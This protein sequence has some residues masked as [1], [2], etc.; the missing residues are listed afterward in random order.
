MS[1][2]S[3]EEQF[4]AV[5]AKKYEKLEWVNKSSY[6]D[7]FLASGQFEKSH[8]VLDVGTGTGIIAHS[9]APHVKDVVGVD[10]SEEMLLKADTKQFKNSQWIF[11]VE[12]GYCI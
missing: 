6:L 12:Y 1:K 9:L 5:R 4:W 8:R 10:I 3:T 11:F 7:A 2:A